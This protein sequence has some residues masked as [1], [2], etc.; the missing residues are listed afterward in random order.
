MYDE[1]IAHM[2]KYLELTA[3]RTDYALGYLG[4]AY[5]RAGQREKAREILEHCKIEPIDHM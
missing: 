3:G 2:Q 5:G 4:Y 1:A